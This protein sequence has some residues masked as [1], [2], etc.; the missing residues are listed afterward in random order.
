MLS[1]GRPHGLDCLHAARC[2][3]CRMFTLYFSGGEAV[4]AE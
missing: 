4:H 3:H 2:E 1:G